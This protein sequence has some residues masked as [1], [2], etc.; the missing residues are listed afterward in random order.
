MSENIK[1]KKSD[2]LLELALEEQLKFDE[3]MLKYEKMEKEAPDHVF[4]KEH[5]E[6]MQKI[7]KM[8]DKGEN[9]FWLRKRRR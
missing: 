3:E 1:K 4:S 6:K 2:Y 9:I 7:F 8:A 5:N